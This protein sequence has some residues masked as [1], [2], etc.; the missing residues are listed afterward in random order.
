MVIN[1]RHCMK[2]KNEYGRNPYQNISEEKKKEHKKI[3][4]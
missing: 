3:Q 1:T 4:T 2:K